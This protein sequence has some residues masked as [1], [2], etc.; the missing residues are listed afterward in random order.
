MKLL[1]EKLSHMKYSLIVYVFRLYIYVDKG[2]NRIE[3]VEKSTDNLGK[4][5]SSNKV[6]T[7]FEHSSVIIIYLHFQRF[8]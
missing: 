1:K 3:T 7:A 6:E 4:G 8:L 2:A 5:K